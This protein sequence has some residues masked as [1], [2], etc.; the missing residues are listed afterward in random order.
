MDRAYNCRNG[1]PNFKELDAAAIM[2]SGDL[3]FEG[4]DMGNSGLLYLHAPEKHNRPSGLNR[5]RWKT[6]LKELGDQI[7][8]EAGELRKPS[9]GCRHRIRARNQESGIIVGVVETRGSS[10]I[11]VHSLDENPL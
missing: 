1:S 10:S 6:P 2:V 5:K 11:I 8:R 7:N 4:I 3:S 9:A